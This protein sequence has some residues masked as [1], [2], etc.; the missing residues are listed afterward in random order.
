MLGFYDSCLTL[1]SA[2]GGEKHRT[3]KTERVYTCRRKKPEKFEDN[4]L[5]LNL[6]VR[7]AVGIPGKR[8]VKEITPFN[9]TEKLIGLGSDIQVYPRLK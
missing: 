8:K 5:L 2:E 7:R 1:A 4:K 6:P 3:E 9:H